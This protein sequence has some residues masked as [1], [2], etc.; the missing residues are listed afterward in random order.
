MCRIGTA[1]SDNPNYCS[2]LTL[3]ANNQ[4][5]IRDQ[6]LSLPKNSML[7]QFV[8]SIAQQLHRSHPFYEEFVTAG[9]YYKDNPDKTFSVCFDDESYVNKADGVQIRFRYDLNYR[10]RK[11][12][13]KIESELVVSLIP[14]ELKEPTMRGYTTIRHKDHGV[15]FYNIVRA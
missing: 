1:V 15:F 4:K 3:D 13:C 11:T 2:I 9:Q 5:E 10:T 14:D 8:D 7:S 6:L 12:Y